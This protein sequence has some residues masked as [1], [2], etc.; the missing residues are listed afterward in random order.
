MG[1]SRG[2]EVNEGGVVG[3]GGELLYT[4]PSGKTWRG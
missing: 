2:G 4:T 3:V 1:G